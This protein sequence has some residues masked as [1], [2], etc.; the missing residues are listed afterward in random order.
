MAALQTLAVPEVLSARLR[1][2]LH[3]HAASSG[4]MA[5][6]TKTKPA[7]HNT[8]RVFCRLKRYGFYSYLRN[9]DEG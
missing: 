6:D 2:A 4:G 1:L 7:W 5:L 9:T 3:P 8:L